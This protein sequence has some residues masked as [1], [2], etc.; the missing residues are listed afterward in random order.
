MTQRLPR[1]ELGESKG[2]ARRL[3]LLR[4]RTARWFLPPVRSVGADAPDTLRETPNPVLS[5]GLK[6]PRSL[7]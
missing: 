1:T 6:A 4:R 5:R 3:R 7:H 2:L